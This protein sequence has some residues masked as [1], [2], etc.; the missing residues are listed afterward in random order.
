M[1]DRLIAEFSDTFYNMSTPFSSDPQ[2]TASVISQLRQFRYRAVTLISCL[3]DY[4]GFLIELNAW[5]ETLPDL[6]DTQ[7]TDSYDS[8]YIE[9][10]LQA[11]VQYVRSVMEA[12]T[13]STMTKLELAEAVGNDTMQENLKAITSLY[14]YIDGNVVA[15]AQSSVQKLMVSTTETYLTALEYAGRLQTHFD[16]NTEVAE[17][18]RSMKIWQQPVP[19]IDSSEVLP[20][21]GHL[22]WIFTLF[23]RSTASSY[24]RSRPAGEALLARAPRSVPPWAVCIMK[25]D[26]RR[27]TYPRYVT[28]PHWLKV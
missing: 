5:L 17:G 8:G 2:R 26:G 25:P 4:N 13:L 11:G 19:N 23:A 14:D 18:A 12:Y 27:L 3:T 24:V 9:T 15:S 7:L 21:N 28:S 10:A 20:L 16:G 1:I 6:L 22:D